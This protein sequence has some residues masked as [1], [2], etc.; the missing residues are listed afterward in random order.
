MQ[1]FNKKNK[2]WC[3]VKKSFENKKKNGKDC[4]SFPSSFFFLE[5]DEK[6]EEEKKT[7]WMEY[8]SCL[9]GK[10]NC[11]KMEYLL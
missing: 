9:Q 8:V 1:S 2:E 11:Y 6:E 5:A 4:F 3:F 7:Q 10:H